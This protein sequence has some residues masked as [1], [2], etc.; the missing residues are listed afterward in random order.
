M[1]GDEYFLGSGDIF[2]LPGGERQI[3][4]ASK[5]MAI[6]WVVTNEPQLAFTLQNQKKVPP[7]QNDYYPASEIKKRLS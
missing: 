7:Q 4:Q 1:S 6:L 5:E 2:V 3:H